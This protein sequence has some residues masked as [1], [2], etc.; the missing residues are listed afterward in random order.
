MVLFPHPYMATGKTI[1]STIWTFVSKTKS[2]IFNTLSRFVIAF[3]PRSKH[4]LISWLQSVSTVILKSKKIKSAT[5]SIVS[6]SICHEVM[7]LDVMILA[8]WMLSFKPAFSL[9]SFT[10]IKR[11]FSSSL[12]YAIRVVSSVY[13]RLLIFLPAILIPVC[14]SSRPSFHMMCSAGKLNNHVDNI[15]P[16]RTL[17]PILNLSV[18]HVHQ[19]KIN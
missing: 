4:L 10:F 8:F 7:G 19:L 13:L 18:F 17:F 16:W 5:V 15:Q 14:A 11:L 6:P 12:L 2:W 1:V 3:L 9:S